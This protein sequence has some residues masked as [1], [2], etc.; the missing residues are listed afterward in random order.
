MHTESLTF[1]LMGELEFLLTV[2]TAAMGIAAFMKTEKQKRKTQ[3]GVRDSFF[4]NT[5]KTNNVM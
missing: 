4:F 1:G 3:E 2:N 5:V